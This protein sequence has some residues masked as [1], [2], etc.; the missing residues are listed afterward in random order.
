MREKLTHLNNANPSSNFPGSILDEKITNTMMDLFKGQDR[1]DVTFDVNGKLPNTF[2]LDGNITI[3]ITRDP[4]TG[5]IE[6][7][8]AKAIYRTENCPFYV[9]DTENLVFINVNIKDCLAD[10]IVV[11]KNDRDIL[12]SSTYNILNDG[13]LIFNSARTE[14]YVLVDGLEYYKHTQ[15]NFYYDSM[16]RVTHIQAIE[17]LRNGGIV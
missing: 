11:V 14:K 12:D 16:G 9:Y 13:R 2:T 5:R 3:A 17:P 6:F 15:Y 10:P 4:S 8:D 7:I 1:F